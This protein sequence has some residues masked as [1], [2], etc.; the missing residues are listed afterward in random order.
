LTDVRAENLRSRGV[1]EAR[2]HALLNR[3]KEDSVNPGNVEKALRAPV[4]GVIPNDYKEVYSAT[5]KGRLV[6]E[7]T[8]LGQAY[9]AFARK[10]LH[11][12]EPE[13]AKGM[14]ERFRYAVGRKS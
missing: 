2:I 8:E 11:I 14:F 6:G 1:E 12:P 9:T 3:W 4:A 5:I 10:L 13:P 7:E